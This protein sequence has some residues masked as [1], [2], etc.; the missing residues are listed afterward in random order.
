MK[1]YSVNRCFLTLTSNLMCRSKNTVFVQREHIDWSGDA[2]T[3]Q[4]AH[5]KTDREGQD[6]GNKRH[7]YANPFMPAICPVL[8][9]ARYFAVNSDKERESTWILKFSTCSLSHATH[10]DPLMSDWSVTRRSDRKYAGL[11]TSPIMSP[12]SVKAL[13]VLIVGT[14]TGPIRDWLYQNSL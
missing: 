10:K 5:S 2:M 13:C 1:V 14:V 12:L 9:I 6:A 7:V 8:S 11:I 3:I 4:F